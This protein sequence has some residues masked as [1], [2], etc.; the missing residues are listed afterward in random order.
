MN[1]FW[2]PIIAPVL[3]ILQPESIL[4]IGSGEG[5]NT[6]NL[7]GFCE[8]SGAILHAVDP[9][10]RF[11]VE[12]LETKHRNHFFFYR[13]LSLNAISQVDRFDI[14]LI[15]G[16]HNWFTVFN[17]L[18]L[19]EKRSKALCRPFPLVMIHDIAWPYGRRDLY[20]NP[21]NIPEA[22][23]KPYRKAGM[24]PESAELFD[25]RGLNQHLWN[26]VYENDLQNGVLTAVEDFLNETVEKLEFY[27]LPGP[28]GLGVLLPFHLKE[29]KQ[30]LY[31]FLEKFRID[32]DVRSL[33]DMIEEERCHMEVRLY[34]K[35]TE[36]EKMERDYRKEFEIVRKKLTDKDSVI[37]NYNKI[38]EKL[39]ADYHK[40]IERMEGERKKQEKGMLE[41]FL[42]ERSSLLRDIERLRNLAISSMRWKIGNALGRYGRK[43]MFKRPVPTALDEMKKLIDSYNEISDR[44]FGNKG[45]KKP[46]KTGP[47]EAL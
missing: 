9:R 20:Y 17:E 24:R 4:E 28:G 31:V 6:F 33:V 43:L 34:E 11:D 12:I 18:K 46:G 3:G 25:E 27:Y 8:N 22:F 10:P 37:I 19:I 35:D 32:P 16:D 23:R 26:A 47:G 21:E 7:V 13:S 45:W 39:K 44:D 14:V 15:D 1:R 2:N 40:A 38:V 41:A 42:K 5:K 36:L 30:D 29:R